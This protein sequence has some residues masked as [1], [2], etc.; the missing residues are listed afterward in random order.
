MDKLLKTWI[1]LIALALTPAI[2]SHMGGPIVAALILLLAW[3]KAR[4]ILRGFLHLAPSS[5]WLSAFM[6]PLAI[7]LMALWGLHMAA[8]PT[9]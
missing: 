6:V 7:W 8:Y 3:L 4:L 1:F 9:G 5:G 2:L